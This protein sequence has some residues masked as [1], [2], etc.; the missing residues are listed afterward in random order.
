MEN[1]SQMKQLS[2][3]ISMIELKH[4]ISSN[5]LCTY[6][7]PIVRTI[8]FKISNSKLLLAAQPFSFIQNM[9]HK[10][11]SLKSYRKNVDCVFNW[12]IKLFPSCFRIHMNPKCAMQIYFILDQL[13]S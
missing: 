7:R 12:K 2:S 6:L 10:M 3:T 8:I 5:L 11:L 13:L 9:Y 1:Q 4:I